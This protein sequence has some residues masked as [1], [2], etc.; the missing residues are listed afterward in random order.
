MINTIPPYDYIKGNKFN[1]NLCKALGNISL[2]EVSEILNVPKTTF[3]TWAIHDRIGFEVII[4]VHISTG[5]SVEA[6]ALGQFNEEDEHLSKN[7]FTENIQP[8]EY[9]KGKECV[10]ML[11]KFTNSHTYDELSK[12]LGVPKSTFSTWITHKRSAFEI[13]VRLLLK[14]VATADAFYTNRN[15]ALLPPVEDSLSSRAPR[16][17]GI[18]LT[19]EDLKMLE[20]IAQLSDPI[21]KKALAT[22]LI[23]S[24][25]SR[26]SASE[27]SIKSAR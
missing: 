6:L 14:G 16:P 13:F 26:N 21:S 10:E 22:T 8:Y 9:I 23:E 1:E 2:S 3:S 24:V 19:D 18:E 27:N 7:A 4:R 25:L 5:I 12:C 20:A 17:S 15:T 11:K